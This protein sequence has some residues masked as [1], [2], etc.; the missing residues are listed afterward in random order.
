MKQLMERSLRR[1]FDDYMEMKWYRRGDR[2][3]N[4]CNGFRSRNLLT[5]LGLIKEIRVPRSRKRGFEPKVFDRYKRAQ[6]VVDAGILKMYLMGVSTLRDGFKVRINERYAVPIWIIIWMNSFSDSIE[7]HPAF[8][9][10]CSF[11]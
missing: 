10:N 6:D 3:K 1:E 5:T 7:E 4:Y 8:G 9:E 2:R 11:G